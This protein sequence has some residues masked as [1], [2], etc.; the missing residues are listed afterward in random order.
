MLFNSIVFLFSFLPLLLAVYYLTPKKYRNYTILLFSFIFYAW[1]G[2]SYTLI[3]IGSILVNYLFVKQIKKNNAYK[4]SWL[5]IGLIVNIL[6][7]VLFKYLDFLIENINIVGASFKTDYTAIPFKHIVLPLGISFFTFQQMSLIWDVYRNE[8]T[9]KTTLS[10]IALYISL[11]PQ[12]IAGPIVRY[13]D[14]VGQIKHRV[15]TFLLFRSGIQRFVLGLFKKVIIANT[16]GE[17]ADTIFSS[18]FNSLDSPT[19]WLGI[20]A[21]S[22]QIYFDF[23]GYSDM[24]IGLGR[25]F[26]FRILEN[27]NFPYISKSIQ[28]FWRRWHISLSTWFRDYVYIPLG[29]NRNGAY[30]TYFNLIIVFLLTGMWHGATWSFVIW[31]LFHG[32]FLIMERIGFKAVLDRLPKAIQWFYTILVVMIGWV[33]F[34]VEAFSEALEY[35]IKL[36]SFEK[37]KNISFLTYLDNERILVLLLAL[38]SSSLFFVKIKTFLDNRKLTQTIVFQ[39]LLDIGVVVLLLICIVY[40]N[41]GSYSPFIYFR[42]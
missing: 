18:S 27:F 1:G 38:L 22:L 5:I 11:F 9:E 24:A 37:S 16:C 32:F 6:I 2:V 10:N 30:R 15:S 28:E 29:G 31:G 7:I 23:S 17:L 20:I 21:Y 36:F 13:N 39:S 40:I 12:L 35:I 26:G 34:R 14:I 19:A 41:S 42:F 4:K 8:N 3:L 25:M 33:L